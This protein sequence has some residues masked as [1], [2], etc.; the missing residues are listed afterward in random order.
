MGLNQ[1]NNKLIQMKKNNIKGVSDVE[2][3]TEPN[4]VTHSLE[5]AKNSLKKKKKT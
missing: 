1:E 2:F 4:G 5:K 3:C